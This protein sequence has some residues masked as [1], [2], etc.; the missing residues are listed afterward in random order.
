MS[1]TLARVDACTPYTKPASDL[2][3]GEVIAVPR[4]GKRAVVKKGRAKAYLAYPK[5]G[6]QAYTKES[7][8]RGKP[9]PEPM[10]TGTVTVIARMNGGVFSEPSA[11]SEESKALAQARKAAKAKPASDK[12]EAVQALLALLLD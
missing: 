11:R 3:H 9:E 5:R 8:E 7:I 1:Q 2:A 6:T 4:V 12:A 10:P